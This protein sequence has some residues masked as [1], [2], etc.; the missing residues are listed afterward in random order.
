MKKETPE[1]WLEKRNKNA[2]VSVPKQDKAT[3]SME[4]GIEVQRKTIMEAQKS[5]ESQKRARG[6]RKTNH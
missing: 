4:D 1:A 6:A 5:R 3:Q 2:L